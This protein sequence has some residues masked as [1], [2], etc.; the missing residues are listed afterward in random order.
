MSYT[1]NGLLN[2]VTIEGKPLQ[3]MYPGKV[4]WVNNSEVLPSK[5]IRGNDTNGKGTYLKP[6][7][8]I[9]YAIGR[10]TASRGDI[11]AVMPGHAETLSSAGAITSDVAGVAIVGLGHGSL[12]PSVTYDTIASADWV[13]SAANCAFVNL[14][15]VA[16]LLDVVNAFDVSA[17]ADNCYWEGVH[18]TEGAAAT[19]L[20][21]VRV[22]DFA[23]GTDNIHINN[24]SYHGN[25]AQNTFVILLVAGVGLYMDGNYFAKDIDSG[26]AAQM[27]ASGL[28]S[29][30]WIK[31]CFWRS[32]VDGAVNIEFTD[33]DNNGVMT[34]CYFSSLD[35]SGYA[36]GAV[37]CTGMH[38]FE[39][40]VAGDADSF[41]IVGGG[42][43]AA[44]ITGL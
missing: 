44:Y 24:C 15:I 25:D 21:W 29:N 2:G 22:W 41:G 1:T 9:D 10:C 5:G 40:Y 36:A 12:R 33:T 11:I 42:A 8:T 13:V 34:N 7:R 39:C 43:G 6:W 19:N 16:N 4:F 14:S 28:M 20:N 18:V 35:I 26:V 37:N 32:N 17:T 23:T 38:C 31:N 3:M 30:V 27:D